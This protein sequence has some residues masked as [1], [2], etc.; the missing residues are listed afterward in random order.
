MVHSALIWIPSIKEYKRFKEFNNTHHMLLMKSQEEELDFLYCINNLLHELC[1]EGLDLSKITILDKYIIYLYLRMMYI[2]SEL[3]VVITCPECDKTIPT[4]IDL[5][6]LVE[7]NLDILDKNYSKIIKT[8]DIEVTCSIPMIKNEYDLAFY[9]KTKNVSNIDYALSHNILSHID[10]IKIKDKVINMS[11]LD[12]ES[13]LMIFEKMPS[14][15]FRAIN[16]EFIHPISRKITPKILNSA[17]PTEGCKNL[18]FE[19]NLSNI[20]DIIKLLFQGSPVST[21][22]ENFYLSKGSKVSH[23]YLST[24]SPAERNLL[25]EFHVEDVKSQ[26]SGSNGGDNNSHINVGDLG[27]EDFE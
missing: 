20:N 8:G 23:E 21:L 14:S 10:K 7:N 1:V 15:L 17:C 26:N 13:S 16:N 27:F 3:S 22:Q 18:D 19:L 12:V 6:S 2:G 11:N 9:I 5:N 25:L 24:I 4:N